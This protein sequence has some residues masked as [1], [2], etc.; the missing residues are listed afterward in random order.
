MVGISIK[1]KKRRKII[2]KDKYQLG[3]TM[4]YQV[5]IINTKDSKK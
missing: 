4:K 5:M 3:Q 1:Y 2:E